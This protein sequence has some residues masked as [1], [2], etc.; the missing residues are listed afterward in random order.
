MPGERDHLQAA[1]GD[2]LD[3]RRDAW[4]DAPDPEQPADERPEDAFTAGTDESPA[5][6]TEADTADVVEQ[7]IEVPEGDEH[8]QE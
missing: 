5:D 1:E 7:T 6:S 4:E 2:L 3:Q 8:V